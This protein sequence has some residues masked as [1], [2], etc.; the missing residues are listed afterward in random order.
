MAGFL[1]RALE[2]AGRGVLAVGTAEEGLTLAKSGSYDIVLTDINPPGMA[3]LELLSKIKILLPSCDVIIMTGGPS[4]E[5]AVKA[6][7]SGAYDF[8]IKPFSADALYFTLKRCLE[9]R[10]LSVEPAAEKNLVK[11]AVL[12]NKPQGR[13]VVTVEDT[14]KCADVR[15]EDTGHGIPAEK[16]QPVCD[17]SY[18]V[19]DY[20]TRE[21]GGLGLAIIKQVAEPTKGA[22]TFPAW[23][24]RAA[25][26]RCSCQK[27]DARPE[28]L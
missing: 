1:L 25:S 19:A 16:L 6:V 10:S 26:L 13:V 23:R 12:F 11:N 24:A 21:I 3:G 9:K 28:A 5:S 15:V 18:Q 17:P 14:P 27:N 4:L 22:S 20:F 2:A 7:N 8:L